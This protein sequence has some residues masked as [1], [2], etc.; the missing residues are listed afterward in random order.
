MRRAANVDA[1][2]RFGVD[3]SNNAYR[4]AGQ[5]TCA[6]CGSEFHSYMPKKFCGQDCYHKSRIVRVERPCVQ[7]GTLYLPNVD[8]SKFC[9][10]GCMH[11]SRPRLKVYQPKPR[12]VHMTS[13][14]QCGQQFRSSPSQSPGN[15]RTRPLRA[16]R[17]HRKWAEG[18][19]L[20]R[21]HRGPMQAPAPREQRA[22]HPLPD[23]ASGTDDLFG[24]A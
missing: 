5:K 4:G 19:W 15:P 2:D 17:D 21:Y 11:A 24:G 22:A 1:L 9:S 18:R 6:H 8:S 20:D 10:K 16:C 3:T 14:G 7:C 12:A 13:C 23:R